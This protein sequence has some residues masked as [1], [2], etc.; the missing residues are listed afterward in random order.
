LEQLEHL[1][2]RDHRV[3]PDWLDQL[4]LPEQV[5]LVLPDRKVMREILDT[6][7]HKVQPDQPEQQDPVGFKVDKAI[8]DQLATRAPR[9]LLVREQLV[10][11][12]R[13]DQLALL[14]PSGLM[15][16]REQPA[17]KVFKG[18]RVQ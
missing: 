4:E 13:K 1:E 7:G 12:V 11:R 16:Q 5:L 18:I 6:R 10:L 9:A 3:L 17:H 8:R 14:A 15:E 2:P